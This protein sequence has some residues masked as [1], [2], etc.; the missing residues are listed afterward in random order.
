VASGGGLFF[1][2]GM[3]MD[4]SI[5]GGGGGDASGMSGQPFLTVNADNTP[6]PSRSMTGR[7][8]GQS[9][10]VVLMQICLDLDPAYFNKFIE[11]LYKRNMGYTVIGVRWKA[12]DPL[13]RASNGFIYGDGQVVEYEILVEGLLFRNWTLPL[14]P[15]NVRTAL[16]IPA[17]A[18]PAQ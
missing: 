9:Y 7:A 14:M 15:S 2:P 4:M 12:A 6:E 11:Q 5:A 13:D 1:V 10:D 16:A 18:A 17:D 3:S 8:S